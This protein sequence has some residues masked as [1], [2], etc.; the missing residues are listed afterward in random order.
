MADPVASAGDGPGDR[1]QITAAEYK[2][3]ALPGEFMER[4]RDEGVIATFPDYETGLDIPA[5]KRAP[6]LPAVSLFARD[7]RGQSVEL[8]AHGFQP[9]FYVR[10]N[11][12]E[13][14]DPE[15]LRRELEDVLRVANGRDDGSEPTEDEVATL[16][17]VALERRVAGDRD[18]Q[19]AS[20][21]AA[22]KRRHFESCRR[23]CAITP[24]EHLRSVMG[25]QTP[26][27]C[28]AD[29]GFWRITLRKPSDVRRARDHLQAA[30]RETF[31][32]NVLFPTRYLIARGIKAAQWTEL[33]ADTMIIVDPPTPAGSDEPGASPSWRVH[34]WHAALRPTAD[35]D[36]LHGRLRVMAFDCEMAGRRGH[37]PEPEVDAV[38]MISSICFDFGTDP[39]D[40]A[41]PPRAVLLHTWKPLPDGRD[42]LARGCEDEEEK[43]ED[44]TVRTENEQADVLAKRDA[45]EMAAEAKKR[46]PERAINRALLPHL[47]IR[48]YDSEAQML[49]AWR[50]AMRDEIDPDFLS[51]Y[52]SIGFDMEYLIRRAQT[53][54]VG[55]AFA[56]LGRWSDEAARLQEETFSSKAYGT[57]TVQYAKIAG[58][59]QMDLLEVIRRDHKL[60]SYKLDNV[61]RMFL[62]VAKLDL[63]HTEI[64]PAWNSDDPVRLQRLSIYCVKDSLL[65]LRLALRLTKLVQ[66]LEVARACGVLP[67]ELLRRGA[68]IRVFTQLLH[69]TQ[70]ANYVIPFIPVPEDAGET[71]Y[72]G[73][74]V[75]EPE[76]GYYDTLLPTVD[77]TGLYPSIMQA[78][79]LSFD[80]W[81]NPVHGMEKTLA[82][83][84]WQRTKAG[85]CFVHASTRKGILCSMLDELLALR[86]RAKAE[87]K[88]YKDTNPEMYDIMDAR[89][90]AYKLLCNAVYGFTG[91]IKGKLPLVAISESVTAQ[92]RTMIDKT[93]EMSEAPRWIEKTQSWTDGLPIGHELNPY[94]NHVIYGDTDSCMVDTR[95][96]VGSPDAPEERER[97]IRQAIAIGI[98]LAKRVTA[99]YH[100]LGPSWKAVNLD[101]EK[102]GGPM[103]LQA[104]KRYAMLIHFEDKGALKTKL[105]WRGMEV[106]R[107]DTCRM[108][109]ITQAELLH[110]LLIG[111]SP[112]AA[113]AYIREQVKRMMTGDVDTSLLVISKEL[114]REHYAA[115]Q[116]HATLVEKMRRRQAEALDASRTRELE[117]TMDRDAPP[118]T[119]RLKLPSSRM[120]KSALARMWT[121]AS[122][123]KK[124]EE[125]VA[126]AAVAIMKEEE[127]MDIEVK[128]EAKVEVAAPPPLE[129][130]AG[131]QLTP[132]EELVLATTVPQI[133]DRVEYVFVRTP[134]N[135]ELPVQTNPG[136]ARSTRTMWNM[137]RR[138]WG[139]WPRWD[140][141]QDTGNARYADAAIEGRPRPSGLPGANVSGLG[142]PVVGLLRYRPAKRPHPALLPSRPGTGAMLAL[143]RLC[144]A[145]PSHLDR[146]NRYSAWRWTRIPEGVGVYTEPYGVTPASIYRT[147]EYQT[148]PE[149]R[150]ESFREQVLNGIPLGAEHYLRLFPVW[151]DYRG[152]FGTILPQAQA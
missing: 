120:Q 131:A 11:D 31:E 73:A 127:P 56:R 45:E 122:I 90:L 152:H 113:E 17:A 84:L 135:G 76:C 96:P 71:K 65:A 12:A 100:S 130:G 87:M 14:A 8:I 140:L 66:L 121:A 151:M 86:G 111:Q 42:W 72:R 77:Y 10:R 138:R 26:E 143:T 132:Y 22:F 79:N 95:I 119:K 34:F 6:W 59:V 85:H 25:Y 103:I 35:P 89:Q 24:C 38:I 74:R 63:H 3:R 61:A 47:Q 7:E 118:D 58:R 91:A 88:K 36:G 57:R 20:R 105:L 2:F 53:L 106:A 4:A 125:D 83:E 18:A 94:G 9:F 23:V 144:D 107:R 114:T 41:T 108:T 99:Y 44:E 139:S 137:R 146:M 93:K 54:E 28:A 149:A 37:F 92:G 129:E 124:E 19:H 16:E 64:T 43:R 27:A 145:F 46:A 52:N 104:K 69:L 68:S 128:P 1:F 117:A 48:S 15:M 141:W 30:G 13:H 55:D 133:G 109:A 75:I 5:P 81:L 134:W 62:G 102:T 29:P 150:R 51:G 21:T 116:P 49:M 142:H 97:N 126:A 110:R 147:D 33:V 112:A 82:P 67:T 70:Q 80:T 60:R 78:L 101:Y 136:A 32:S 39:R 40:P 50:T 148:V 123:K 115:A 98:G